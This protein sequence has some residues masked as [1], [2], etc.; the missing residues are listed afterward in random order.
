MPEF[1]TLLIFSAAVLGLLLAPGPN[2]AFLFAHSLS[3]GPQG[4]LRRPGVLGQEGGGDEDEGEQGQAEG[5]G[6]RRGRTPGA[7]VVGD[8]DEPGEEAPE[9]G[10]EHERGQDDGP[11]LA[12]RAERR[13]DGRRAAPQPFTEPAVSP[14]TK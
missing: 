13:Q 2:M 14:R 9:G 7:V 12:L 8:G 4:G 11:P 3:H 1:H 6:G 10:D 5:D